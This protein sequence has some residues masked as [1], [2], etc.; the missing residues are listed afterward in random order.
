MML[1]MSGFP[2]Y[3]LQMALGGYV[4]SWR[5]SADNGAGAVAKVDIGKIN[6]LLRMHSDFVVLIRAFCDAAG[7][8]Q[9]AAIPLT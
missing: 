4:A 5:A 9:K 6:K 1:L 2:L 7:I 3:F 8:T